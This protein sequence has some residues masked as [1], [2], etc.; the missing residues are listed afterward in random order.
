M[1]ESKKKSKGKGC[2][3]VVLGIIGIIVIAGI[4]GGKDN[5]KQKQA[6]QNNQSSQSEQSSD[7]N[8]PTI[9]VT[10]TEVAKAF[11][12]NEL[13]GKETYTGKRATITGTVTSIGEA[14]GRKYVCLQ[15]ESFISLQCYFNDDNLA[16]VSDLRKGQKVTIVGTIGE[17]A[18][19]VSV[20]DCT[21]K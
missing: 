13:K 9:S 5:N 14:F 18:V 11:N 10:A 6:G 15:G 17:M 21:L 2:L 7:D 8:E 4:F 3:F 1:E 20:D 19:N 12:A 16:G